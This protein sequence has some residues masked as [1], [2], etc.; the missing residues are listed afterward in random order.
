[1]RTPCFALIALVSAVASGQ[2]SSVP[3]LSSGASRGVSLQ[4]SLRAD[5][6]SST[7]AQRFSAEGVSNGSTF[8]RRVVRDAANRVYFGY[9]LRLEPQRPP[10]AYLATFSKLGATLLNSDT[11]WTLKPLPAIPDPRVVHDGDTITIG[12]FVDPATGDK[13]IDDIRIDPPRL[14]SRVHPALPTARSVPT[15]SGEA[16]EFS[17]GDAELQIVACRLSVNGS[18]KGVIG[19]TVRGSLVWLYLPGHGRYVLSLAPR[20]GLDFK[21]SGEVRGGSISFARDGDS[22]NLESFTPMAPGDAP[23]LLYILH[24]PQW[25]PTSENQKS[26][27]AIGTVGAAELVALKQN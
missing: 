10:G 14:V 6:P 1:M 19:H 3:S 13:L 5:P 2:L 26:A 23:Y 7:L 11:V 12:L 18:L 15:I 17:A 4:P 24:D 8:F 25:E 22:I 27:P 20:A 21:Q 9:E 16:R